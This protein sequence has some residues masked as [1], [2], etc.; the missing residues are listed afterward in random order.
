MTLP[1]SNFSVFIPLRNA[2]ATPAQRRLLG[3]LTALL[4]T[5]IA[6]LVWYVV[7]G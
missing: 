4:C 7:A 1:L 6:A 3:L 5:M 2:T